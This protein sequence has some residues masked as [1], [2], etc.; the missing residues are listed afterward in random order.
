MVYWTLLYIYIL[1]QV[2]QTGLCLCEII[3]FVCNKNPPCAE[4]SLTVLYVTAYLL[5]HCNWLDI[6]YYD[7]CSR[8]WRTSLKISI[9]TMWPE[10]CKQQELYVHG[11]LNL[12]IYYLKAGNSNR[13]GCVCLSA[14]SIW[15]HSWIFMKHVRQM[16][17]KKAISLR[18]YLIP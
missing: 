10:H 14:N 11:T 18:Y 13:S 2:I 3:I 5:A 9:T 16:M 6:W 4:P 15:T 8:S 7:T 17:H 1:T 12:V